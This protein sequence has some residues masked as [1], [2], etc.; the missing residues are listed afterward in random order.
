MQLI[1]MLC[2]DTSGF[3]MAAINDTFHFLVDHSCNALTIWLGMAD[4]S[5]DEHLITAACIINQTNCIRHTVLCN[6]GTCCLCC[7]LNIL[8][9]TR[10]NI[11]KDQFFRDTSAQRYNNILHHLALGIEHIVSF[12]QRHCI[13]CCT[14]TCRNNRYGINRS[15]IRKQME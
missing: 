6:H 9:G 12:R 10:C 5:A 13:T 15:Y 3:L 14:N 11:I 1:Q 8:G 2:N 4:I 7:R